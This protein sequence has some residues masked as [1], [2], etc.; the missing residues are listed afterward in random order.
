MRQTMPPQSIHKDSSGVLSPHN[1][2]K[3][4][5]IIRR[6]VETFSPFADSNTHLQDFTLNEIIKE[7][8]L[9]QSK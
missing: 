1:M 2:S 8:E 7:G 9:Q 6:N 4:F 3:R 5:E